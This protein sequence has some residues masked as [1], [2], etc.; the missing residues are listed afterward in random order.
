MNIQGHTFTDEQLAI[1]LDDGLFLGV[2]G[3]G[4]VYEYFPAKGQR[5]NLNGSVSVHRSVVD[6]LSGGEVHIKDETASEEKDIIWHF[7]LASLA[8]GLSL[9]AETNNQSFKYMTDIME[10]GLDK[11]TDLTEYGNVVIQLGLF[12]EIKY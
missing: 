11:A 1:L 3:W 8:R 7:D 10:E 12:G 6:L 5:V 2:P 9:F 4:R